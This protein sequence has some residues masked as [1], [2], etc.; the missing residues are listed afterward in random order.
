MFKKEKTREN[1]QTDRQTDRETDNKVS[2]QQFLRVL[3]NSN[4]A[5]SV[6]KWS[7][8]RTSNMLNLEEI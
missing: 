7:K 4:E 1:R 3:T 2:E 5:G 6:E 8:I